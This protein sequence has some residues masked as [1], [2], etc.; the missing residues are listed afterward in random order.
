MKLNETRFHWIFYDEPL[1]FHLLP[2][3]VIEV[4]MESQIHSRETMGNYEKKKFDEDSATAQPLI[5]DLH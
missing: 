3:E 1:R 5:S 2:P 4:L